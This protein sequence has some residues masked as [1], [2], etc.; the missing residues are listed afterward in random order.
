MNGTSSWVAPTSMTSTMLGWFTRADTRAS[1]K[2]RASVSAVSIVGRS[3]LMATWRSVNAL[4][5]DH[6][7]A[8]PPTPN[9]SSRRYFPA[10]AS[11]VFLKAMLMPS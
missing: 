8:I 7:S 5:A 1:R 4:V 6:T 10:I 9:R 2:N 3:S 11:A